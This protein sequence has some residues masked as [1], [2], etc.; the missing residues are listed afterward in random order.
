MKRADLKD[1][2]RFTDEKLMSMGECA[3]YARTRAIR[4]VLEEDYHYHMD[5]ANRIQALIRDPAAWIN[6]EEPQDG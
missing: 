1:Y 3:A 6:P 2:F 4:S 5:V